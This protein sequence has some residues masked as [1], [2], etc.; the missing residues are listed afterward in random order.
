[1]HAS[2]ATSS[3]EGLR[4]GLA[5]VRSCALVGL[6]L[7]VLAGCAGD[8]AQTS[9]GAN[10]PPPTVV[11]IDRADYA[12]WFD[13]AVALSG[14]EDMPAELRDRDGGIIETRPK[15]AG[16][17]IEPWDWPRGDLGEAVEAT[18][19]FERR[20]ARFEFLPSGFQPEAGF[21]VAD[22]D[23]RLSGRRTPGSTDPTAFG[24][25]DLS[26]YDGPIEVRVWVWVERAF[27]PNLQRSPWTFSQTTFASDPTKNRPTGDASTRDRS[28]WTPVARDAAMETILLDKLV[29]RTT[30]D[31]PG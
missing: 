29:D 8:D 10:D 25:V 2:S 14:E 11:V 18:L 20:R 30:A 27:T 9:R 12:R 26:R 31:Q 16:S 28:I 3:N 13:A 6:A 1:M 19:S 4:S 15:V 17:L 21:A 5:R 7:T 23:A 22:D 24:A